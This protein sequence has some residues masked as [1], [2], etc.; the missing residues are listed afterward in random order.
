VRRRMDVPP[1][2]GPVVAFCGIARP[3]QFF[4]GLERAGLR[5]A[6]RFVFADHHRYTASDLERVTNA[7]QKAGATALLTTEKDRVR[8]GAMASSLPIQ[9]VSLLIEI[10]NEKAAVDWLV[11]RI[12]AARPANTLP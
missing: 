3:E 6:A 12:L 9:V 1:V 8:L 4:E 10:E 11:S 7:A 2:D 5:V